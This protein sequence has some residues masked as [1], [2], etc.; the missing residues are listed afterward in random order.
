MGQQQLLLIV[1]GAIVVGIAVVF[2]IQLFRQG[3]I[4][5]KRDMMVNE[6][7]NIAS[8]AIGY[9]KKPRVLGGGGN[10]FEG[11]QIPDN[12]KS[13]ENGYYTVS[14]IQINELEI[15]G[16]G[17]EVITDNDSIQVKTTVRSNNFV[18]SIIR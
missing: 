16:T 11:W 10:S 15:I 17:T 13:T 7:S 12:M 1:L 9:Y 18:T 5:S 2:S 4:D 6:S 3:A 8:D 14:N